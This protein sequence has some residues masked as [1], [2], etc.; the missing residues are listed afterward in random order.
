MDLLDYSLL[1]DIEN[2]ILIG[3]EVSQEKEELKNISIGVL[4]EERDEVKRYILKH[5]K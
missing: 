3:P 5:N 1:D 4:K 2:H